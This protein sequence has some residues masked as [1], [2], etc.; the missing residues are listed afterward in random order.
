VSTG[1]LEFGPGQVLA[2]ALVDAEAEGDV[3]AGGPVPNVA[4]NAVA[5]ES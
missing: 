5:F 3:V 4:S 1:D 2:E